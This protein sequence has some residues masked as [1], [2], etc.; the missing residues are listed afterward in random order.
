MRRIV[1]KRTKDLNTWAIVSDKGFSLSELR[2][3]EEHEALEWAIRFMSSFSGI[4]YCLEVDY[5]TH[6]KRTFEEESK[7]ITSN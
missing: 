3:D 6:G 7:K 4:N 2:F 5:G 1:L